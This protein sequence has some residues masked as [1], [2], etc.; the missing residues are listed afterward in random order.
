VAPLGIRDDG[1]LVGDAARSGGA[2][3]GLSE[4]LAQELAP[5]GVKV[6]IVEPGGYW[7][8]LYRTG[9]HYAQPLDA[10]AALREQPEGAADEPTDSEPRLAAEAV[11]KLAASEDPPL[12]LALGGI[13]FDAMI[14]ASRRR[15]ETWQQWEEVSRAAE[16][17]VPM[18]QGYLEREE[19]TR[20]VAGEGDPPAARW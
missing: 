15:I 13:V 2:L 16:H 11:M 14:D 17:A 5:F 7:T 19:E 18:P 6:T 4:A 3:E 1:R 12:R 9:L 8:H 20:P 10:Y